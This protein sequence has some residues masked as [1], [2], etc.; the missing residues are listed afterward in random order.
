MRL[1]L[2]KQCFWRAAVPPS[3]QPDPMC[4][5]KPSLSWSWHGV[6]VR[7]KWEDGRDVAHNKVIMWRRQWRGVYA[8]VNSWK[9]YHGSVES[10]EKLQPSSSRRRF[11]NSSIGSV[12]VSVRP[13]SWGVKTYRNI[14]LC[15]F[16]FA[17]AVSGTFK[18]AMHSFHPC[19]RYK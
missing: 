17:F 4:Q 7:V 2:F 5:W 15:C 6:E 18:G 1:A 12:R 9:W 3:H 11:F 14:K 19:F 8:V 13:G 10:V 16:M